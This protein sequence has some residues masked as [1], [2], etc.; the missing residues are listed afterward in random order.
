MGRTEGQDAV[1]MTVGQEFHGFGN[2]L[3]AAIDALVKTEAISMKK[4]WVQQLS[5]QVLPHHRAMQKNVLYILPKLPAS[6]C[7]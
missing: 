1:P 2:Q 3:D 6:R 7:T 5:V 4:I